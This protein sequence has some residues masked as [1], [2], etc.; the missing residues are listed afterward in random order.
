MYS[1]IARSP[2]WSAEHLSPGRMQ[3][4][5]NV[6]RV[7]NFNPDERLKRAWR[8]R[9][10]D[11]RGSGYDRGHLAPAADMPSPAAMSAS[12]LLS[13]IVA[14]DPQ[15][16]RNLWAAI[17]SAVRALARHREIYVIT[18]PI[19]RGQTIVRIGEGV[20]VPTHL[21]K[22]VYD[23]TNEAAAAYLVENGPDKRHQP[24]SLNELIGLTSID[25]FPGQRLE[26]L[27]LP[28]PRY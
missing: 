13:N 22:L 6:P 16:N 14:Q 7:E 27:K 23:P 18:G 12:F 10:D 1:G 20:M 28:R 4:A 17:E 25:F 11:F 2:I 9:L 24:I 19:W 21:Y 3:A 5:L 15:L 26:R 8:S